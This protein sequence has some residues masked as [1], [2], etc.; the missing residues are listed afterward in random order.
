MDGGLFHYDI[1]A[2]DH[3]TERYRGMRRMWGQALVIAA[4]DAAQ[5]K[6]SFDRAEARAF[7]TRNSY[8]EDRLF[9]DMV[10]GWEIGTV[11]EIGRQ[12]ERT[13][14]QKFKLDDK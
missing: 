8:H 14:W 5:Q 2:Q 11:R 4:R 12:L 13:E 1:R 10:L 3:D 7:L 9:F 6:N